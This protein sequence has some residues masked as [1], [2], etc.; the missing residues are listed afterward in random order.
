M[1]VGHTKFA[2]DRFFGLFKR[3][4]RKA[5]VDTLQDISRVMT[6][7]SKAGKNIPVPT[8]DFFGKRNCEWY[9]WSTF[10]SQYFRT[11]PGITKYHHFLVS[12]E[13]PGVIV[14]KE[15]AD[16]PEVHISLLRAPKSTI[17]NTDVL[18]SIIVPKGL[19]PHRQWYLFEQ[20]RP[21]CH[22]NLSKDFTCPK[23]TVPKPNDAASQTR[24]TLPT[25]RNGE[26]PES[27]KKKSASVA[28]KKTSV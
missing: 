25:K 16:S 8:V 24:T 28:K 7:S 26:G 10:L 3:Q 4:F 18:P 14:C 2:P 17:P 13:D 23:P 21:F 22:S 9:E 1:L 27:S 11:I 5:T 12:Q 6:E 15:L 20:I 19:D